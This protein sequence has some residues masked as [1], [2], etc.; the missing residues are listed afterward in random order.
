MALN[1][2]IFSGSGSADSVV[3]QTTSTIPEYVS[4]TMLFLFH[5]MSIPCGN[6]SIFFG[7]YYYS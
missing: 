3:E 1:M 2:A 7:H 5:C 6:C 4:Y